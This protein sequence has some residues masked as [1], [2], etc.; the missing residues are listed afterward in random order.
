MGPHCSRSQASIQTDCHRPT[1]AVLIPMATVDFVSM[2]LGVMGDISLLGQRTPARDHGGEPSGSGLDGEQVQIKLDG[3]T[4]PAS[5]DLPERFPVDNETAIRF[6]CRN[7]NLC[8]LFRQVDGE[9]L[10]PRSRSLLRELHIS[11]FHEDGHG[12]LDQ[13]SELGLAFDELVI[14][15]SSQVFL[16]TL[17]H[18]VASLGVNIKR[19]RLLRTFLICT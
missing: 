4:S 7:S 6:D 10:C 15:G 2:V 3:R 17:N 11:D 18:I 9:P 14:D 8:C 16:P 1:S 5:S 12:I 19:L 13:L